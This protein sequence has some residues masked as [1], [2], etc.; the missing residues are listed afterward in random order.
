MF[1]SPPAFQA[2]ATLCAPPQSVKLLAAIAKTESG[3]D[4]LAI[5]D[6]TTGRSYR[7]ESMRAAVAVARR[8]LAARHSIDAGLMQVNSANWSRYGLTVRTAFDACASLAAGG[9]ILAG[10]SRYNTGGMGGFA[11]GY[12]ARVVSAEIGAPVKTSPPPPLSQWQILADARES[13]APA[14][15]VFPAQSKDSHE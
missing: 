12:V 4:T 2:A 13:V 7:P 9:A 14:W 3:F 6:D 5:K 1:L 8:L 11:N 10:V 15:N